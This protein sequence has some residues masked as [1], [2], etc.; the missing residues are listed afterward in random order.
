M[1][2]LKRAVAEFLACERIAVVGM[3]R[4]GQS[5]ANMIYRKLA[6]TGHRVFAVNP[7]AQEIEGIRCYSTVAAVPGG[8]DAAVI[9][10]PPSA[11]AAVVESCATAGVRWVWLHR[12]FGEGSM[13]DAAVE[14]CSVHGINVI[15]GGCPMMHLAPVD[16]GHACMRTV[17]RL[18]GGLPV[19]QHGRAAVA[20]PRPGRRAAGAAPAP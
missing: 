9:V 17:L 18:F 15:P 6:Q 8:V 16:P 20:D 4:D 5:P 11:A 14:R 7:N 13:S 10:T 2:D 3:A 19:P 12:S 1:R